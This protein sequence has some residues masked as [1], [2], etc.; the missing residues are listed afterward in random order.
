MQSQLCLLDRFAF[1]PHRHHSGGGEEGEKSIRFHQGFRF[2]GFP[3]NQT[4][5]NSNGLGGLRNSKF[6]L[7]DRGPCCPLFFGFPWEGYEHSMVL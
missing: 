4:S 3:K 5:E 7:T 2:D 1:S 6:A